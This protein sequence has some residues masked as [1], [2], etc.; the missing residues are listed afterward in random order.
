MNK[1]ELWKKKI[2]AE[3]FTMDKYVIFVLHY[4]P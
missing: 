2:N 4:I 1:R 3:S